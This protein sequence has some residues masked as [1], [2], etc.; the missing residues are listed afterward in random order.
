MPRIRLAT[1]GDD[2]GSCLAANR[3]VEICARDGVM[4]NASVM[5]AAPFFADA[6]RRLYDIPGLAIGLHLTL[7]SEW[8]APIW[9]PCA[10]RER[11]RSLIDD[12]GAFPRDGQALGRQGARI[13]EML[14]E[15]EAQLR[16]MEEAGLRPE[17]LDEHMGVADILPD[18][19]EPL[20]DWARGNGLIP[21]HRV[22]LVPGAGTLRER[23]AT[24][25]P[26]DYLWVNH[27]GYDD[28]EMRALGNA[29]YPGA[30]VA[31]ERE[32]DRREWLDPA[33]RET[34]ALYDVAWVRFG[35]LLSD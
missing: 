11:V 28:A 29:S 1:R 34:A 7:T 30:H 24:A 4:R 3:A 23:L 27:P 26:G 16:T 19:R 2:A 25:P 8:D 10:P 22:R 6:A 33:L 18:L 15:A 31:A 9:G 5:A 32:S 21:I 35:E 13:D 20:D 17:Y 14:I 12:R